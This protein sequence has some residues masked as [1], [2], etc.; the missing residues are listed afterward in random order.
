MVDDFAFED[1]KD[2]LASQLSGGNL[3]KLCLACA[4]V[5]DKALIVLDEPCYGLDVK[6]KK[7]FL[8]MLKKKRNNGATFFITTSDD[9]IKEISDNVWL[10]RDKSLVEV[11]E[12]TEFK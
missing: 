9:E 5:N 11:N 6:S 4:M 12:E 10:I 8:N 1:E 2:K 3:R 7:V